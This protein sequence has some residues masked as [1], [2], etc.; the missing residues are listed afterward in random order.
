MLAHEGVSERGIHGPLARS[1]CADRR[2]M[3]GAS[4]RAGC[5]GREAGC[6]GW[7]GRS[8]SSLDRR[9]P[10]VRAGGRMS[11]G[12][13]RAGCPG[14][15]SDVRA[16]GVQLRVRSVMGA[17]FPSWGRMSSLA[18]GAGCP[19]PGQMSGSCSLF[20]FLSSCSFILV[21]GDLSIIPS[22]FKRVSLVP[23]HV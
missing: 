2:R 3:S 22:I 14:L 10:D 18:G 8:R 6:P 7:R 21:L 20:R 12:S 19:G 17:G 23:R 16:D 11:G 5:P 4:R 13:G 9:G 1:L 15:W